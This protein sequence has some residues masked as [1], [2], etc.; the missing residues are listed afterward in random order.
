MPNPPVLLEDKSDILYLGMDIKDDTASILQYY[1]N[2]PD[3]DWH[4]VSS[5]TY[6]ARG[7]FTSGNNGFPPFVPETTYDVI[8]PGIDFDGGTVTSFPATDY[9]STEIFAEKD[10]WVMDGE[11]TLPVTLG[12]PPNTINL[13]GQVKQRFPQEKPF[14][15]YLRCASWV[16]RCTAFSTDYTFTNYTTNPYDWYGYIIE[17]TPD[18]KT[19]D[20]VNGDIKT[21]YYDSFHFAGNIAVSFNYHAENSAA[22]WPV[23]MHVWLEKDGVQYDKQ[24]Y[25]IYDEDTHNFVHTFES[26]PDGCYK[27]M[28]DIQGTSYLWVHAGMYLL[29]Q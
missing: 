20:P 18:M 1:L 28:V 9:Q 15:Y 4:K 16:V 13:S 29:S 22:A 5:L 12:S 6:Y 23:F 14:Q 8:L 2:V 10:L 7:E 19:G 17:T 27:V 21:V 25:N 11:I 26:L 3:F 24:T